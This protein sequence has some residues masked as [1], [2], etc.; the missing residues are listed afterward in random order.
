MAPRLFLPLLLIA[1]FT[2]FS[3][4]AFAQQCNPPEITANARN[5]NIFSP[6]QEMILGDLTY[7]RLSGE[8]RFIKDDK[9]VAYL[10]TIGARLTRHLP[11]TGLKFRFY[12]IDLPDANA[13]NPPGGYVF[14]TR[15][16]I[17]FAQTEDELAG[18]IAHELGHATVRHA[19]SD[20]SQLF[21]KILNV[22]S[23][24]DRKDITEK[25]N[26]L[27]ERERTKRVSQGRKHDDEQQVEAD[28]I[29]L[30]A[31]V[32]AGYDPAAFTS[33]F[34][35]LV[36]VKAKSGN[37]FTNIFGN[38]TPE[39]KR[40]REMLRATERFP[41]PCRENRAAVAS[42]AYL[43]WQAEVVS[44]RDVTI[45]EE[46]P[47]LLWKKVLTPQLRSD[48]SHFAFS[49][50][51]KNFL[52]VDDFAVT[53]LQRD[54]LKVLF[55]IPVTDVRN[56]SFTSD[57][58]FVVLGTNGLRFERWNVA[59]AKAVE[60]RELVVPRDCWEHEFSPDGRY[61][62]CV[63]YSLGVNVLE[64]KTGKR[65][66]S[67]KDFTTLSFLEYLAWIRSEDDEDEPTNTNTF[68]HVEFSPDSRYMLVSRS[69]K[70]R[71]RVRFNGLVADE[72]EDTLLAL[73]LSSLRPL[74]VGGELKKATRRPFVFLDSDRILGMMP[75]M[76]DAG[77]FAFP[78]GKRLARFPLSA[79]E[80]KRSANPNYV[81]LKPLA[82]AR[83]GFFDVTKNALVNGLNNS[84]ATIW[85]DLMVYESASG[86]V[87]VAQMKYDESAKQLRSSVLASIEIPVGPLGQVSAAEVSNNHH[88]LAVSSK[89]RGAVWDLRSGERKMHVRG[90]RGALL[91]DAGQG[92]GDFPKL[93]PMNHTLVLL[94]PE[95][96]VAAAVRDLPEKG[97]RLY[98]RFL[99]VRQSLK[100]PSRKENEKPEKQ[101]SQ[102][103]SESEESLLAKEVRFELR[104]AVHDK[105][106]WSREFHKEAPAYFF[107]DYSG[108][109]VLF[110][111]L[112][113]E[114]GKNKLKENPE[115]AKRAAEMGNKDDDYI[116]EVVDCFA[117]KTIATLLVETG[118]GSIEI[119]GGYTEGEWLVL[120]DSN[121]RVL[122]FSLKDGELRHRFFGAH[123]MVNPSRNQIM[124]EN[125]PGE[126]VLYDLATGT[127]QKKLVFNGPATLARFSLDGKRLLVL[128]A[129]QTAYAFD[130]NQLMAQ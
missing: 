79:D 113:S 73:D 65:V 30:Y 41:A 91:S 82:N 9:L 1:A 44:F 96:N 118:K 110:W 105:V 117:A 55:Q 125:Y 53:V 37:W 48:I 70:F 5:Y 68:F 90:F 10:N 71:F 40:V 38:S 26:L 85:N 100:Q 86:K 101:P 95:N 36:D 43:T 99:L 27:L 52:A 126:L 102:S 128:T 89:T 59:D 13:F 122:V 61:L 114:V 22:T 106:V 104:D 17:A 34:E 119:S 127:A 103:E 92:L 19:A 7:E 81:V 120:Q 83:M 6:D 3:Q 108:R 84:D 57:G 130:V 58:R 33:F 47:G 76:N 69:N 12:I 72:T 24:S 31:M 112:S 21:K 51:G 115:L 121:N 32:A 28:R 42:D 16:L 60:I 45:K 29:G 35:R 62:A 97:T 93:A 87:V 25:Y 2:L 75:N 15:K 80:V 129:G 46:L 23:V 54:P 123:A 109:L 98:G 94:N 77:I 74:S 39:E 116:M 67:K 63:D 64:T 4:Q 78:N 88:W 8:W 111:Y 11:Q 56:A 66:W 107:D 14:V 49:D 124:V 18:V 20:I 50:D